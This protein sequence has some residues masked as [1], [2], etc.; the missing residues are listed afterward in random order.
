[1]SKLKLI[2]SM[3]LGMAVVLTQVGAVH[4]APP[5]QGDTPITGTV[6][7]VVV[8]PVSDSGTQT[9][10]V[11]LLVNGEI[12]T[13]R[14]S[15]ETAAG[16]G[17]VKTDEAGNWVADETKVGTTVD[18][19]PTTIIPD[20]TPV[21]EKQHPVGAKITEFFSGLLG[22]NYE[23]V[24][25]SHSDGLGFGVLTQALWL[26]HK[27]G[28]DGNLFETILDAKKSG[29]YSLVALPDGTIPQNW[30]QFKKTV[31]QGDDDN[32]LGDIMS[33][34]N[35][36]P[37]N[38]GNGYGQETAPGQ[39]KDKDDDHGW[40]KDKPET[41]PGQSKDKDNNGNGNGPVIPPGQNKEKDNNGK[42]GNPP[43]QNKDKDN[44]GKK[45]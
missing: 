27:L 29:D 38:S 42:S 25:S 11:T 31:L 39:N 18:I 20:E 9:V 37:G 45:K 12:Q 15:V 8:E 24:M 33:G 2:L 17:L 19:D 43:G 21:E 44:N 36:Q 26:T 3:L 5:S 34:N 13:V 14:L 32:S 23:M 7:G 35:D 30:G 41:P 40:K 16:L 28:G 10:V 4:A 6:Q 22:V 1:M